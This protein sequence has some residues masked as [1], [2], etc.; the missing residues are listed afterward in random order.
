MPEEEDKRSEAAQGAE[1]DVSVE[2]DTFGSQNAIFRKAVFAPPPPAASRVTPER[3]I[4]SRSGGETLPAG[5]RHTMESAIGYDF[6]QVRIHHGAEAGEMNRQF[7][8]LA[9]THRNHIYFRDGTYNPG[10]SEGTRLLAHELTHV[11]Q[12]GYAAR[13]ARGPGLGSGAKPPAVQRTATWSAGAVNEVNN[14]ANTFINGAN[15][16]VT[17]PMLN[18]TVL[19]SGADTR[20]AIARPTL[21]FGSAAAGGV[22][23]KVATV[24]TNT[25]SFRENVLT[26]GPWTLNTTRVAVG[27]AFP[28]LAACT[29]A[30]NSTF[31]AIGKPTDAAMFA[32]NRRHEDHHATDF[33]VS[34]VTALIPWDLKLTVAAASGTVFTAADQAAAES[35]LWTAMGGT[36]D[37]AADNFTNACAAAIAA[38]HATPKGGN[39]TSAN[40][41][42]NADCSTSSIESTNPS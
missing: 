4:E 18:G 28:A 22:T 20:A 5:T 23:A 35:A 32:A 38:F 42:A 17:N 21:A 24:P 11:A 6:S 16:G 31:R 2:E 19:S 8:A 41:T 14:L 36:P 26:P 3:L 37:Q 25:G 30:G 29:G 39:V 33:Q 40:P 13:Q 34:F 9:F 12:Q 7:S 10:T 15:V 1:G 27:A